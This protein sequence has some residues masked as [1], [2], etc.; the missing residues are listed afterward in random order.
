MSSAKG[1]VLSTF[2]LG[3]G[4]LKTFDPY[5]YC[6]HHV[7]TF[8]PG[9]ENMG[10]DPAL[11]Q[12]RNIGSDFSDKDGWSMFHGKVVP[13][14]P[15]HPH[16]GFETVTI[17][18]K[19]IVDHT[20]S[21]GCS[22]RYGNGDTQ[23]MTAGK[24]VQHSE[25][26]PLLNMDKPNPHAG[27]QIWLNLPSKDK[28]CPPAF[29]MFWDEATPYVTLNDAASGKSAK[30]QVVAGALEG[31]TPLAPPPN[32]WAAED[33]NDVA[34]WVVTIPDGCTVT[35]PP[36]RLGAAANRAIYLVQGDAALVGSEPSRLRALALLRTAPS[37]WCKETQHW[38]EV[39]ASVTA[40]AQNLTPLSR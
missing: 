22:G 13:G 2:A 35:L 12:S 24:G 29:A 5:V 1:V 8:P 4:A 20:D 16:R 10:P 32:S 31:A 14:F 40:L 21:M 7:G 11:L 33:A 18:Q 9:M 38:L 34:I 23:W 25:L 30:V 15:A 3:H 26:L 36:A 17:I 19:G 37:T 27:F 28:L 39:T 6:N